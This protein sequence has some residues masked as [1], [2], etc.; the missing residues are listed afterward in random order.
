MSKKKTPRNRVNEIILLGA[1]GLVCLA[2]LQNL[3]ALY[4]GFWAAFMLLAYVPKVNK[5][6]R[7]ELMMAAMYGPVIMAIFGGWKVAGAAALY[8]GVMILSGV[9]A[10]RR[11][12][13]TKV[14]V[15]V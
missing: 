9:K 12:T 6:F 1:A 8:Y 5:T 11:E 4:S 15:S 3:G 7:G 2:A 13:N 14:N 10:L